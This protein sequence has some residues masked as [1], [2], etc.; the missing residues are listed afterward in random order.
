[1]GIGA[2]E[3]SSPCGEVLE[4]AQQRLLGEGIVDSIVN[5]L[6][7]NLGAANGSDPSV[8]PSAAVLSAEGLQE[9]VGDVSSIVLLKQHNDGCVSLRHMLDTSRLMWTVLRAL[10]CVGIRSAFMFL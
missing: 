2:G 8:E 4:R 1:M 5:A 10:W 3:S 7:S 6:L 9:Q